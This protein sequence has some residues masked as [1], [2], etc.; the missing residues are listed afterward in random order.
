MQF[1][2]HQ[3]M[4][5]GQSLP[6]NIRE[7]HAQIRIGPQRLQNIVSSIRRTDHMQCHPP[8]RPA[9]RPAPVPVRRLRVL[10]APPS[11][12]T[13][14]M[15]RAERPFV[16][17]VRLFGAEPG[18]DA[19][20]GSDDV[21]LEPH[22]FLGGALGFGLV[23]PLVHRVHGE[24]PQDEEVHSGRDDGQAE[25][26]EDQAEGDVFGFA[27]EGA[28]FLESD[29]VAETWKEIGMHLIKLENQ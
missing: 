9:Q 3:S 21:A 29:V 18:D 4:S 16:L 10:L 23:S 24:E 17:R 12:R 14:G 6:P 2:K 13:Q 26:D 15:A 7:L 8:R 1:I 22:R 27:L 5:Y 25:E 19:A 11:E 20:V 28:F